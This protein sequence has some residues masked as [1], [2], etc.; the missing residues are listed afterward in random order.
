MAKRLVILLG[1]MTF[2]LISLVNAGFISVNPCDTPVLIT[3]DK[4][5]IFMESGCFQIT[6]PKNYNN[7][8]SFFDK[9]NKNSFDLKLYSF[10]DVNSENDK[11]KRTTSFPSMHFT[12]KIENERVS[13][14]SDD[15]KI[16]L[17]YLIRG[18]KVK[19][20]MEI[21][22]WESS[23]S[24]G[25]LE[26][27]TKIH[28]GDKSSSKFIN[29][30][31][32]VDGK[33]QPLITSS[34]I[35]GQNEFIVQTL[36]EGKSFSFLDIDPLY[37][38]DYSPAPALWYQNGNKTLPT[39][40]SFDAPTN[41]TSIM[42]DN[43]TGTT[44][45]INS[46]P[47][48]G[49]DRLIRTRFNQPYQ[50]GYNY[51]IAIYRPFST[52][53]TAKVLPHINSTHVNMSYYV[54]K[55]ITGTGW[56]YINVTEITEFMDINLGYLDY[57]IQVVPDNQITFSEAWLR[58]E[59]NDTSYP[60]IVNCSVTNN[61]LSCDESATII[62]EV[63][64]D[65][66][67]DNVNFTI[68]GTEY[69]GIQNDSEWYYILNLSGESTFNYT[70]DS[71]EACDIF[72]QC[73][74]ENRTEYVYYDC[75][76]CVEDW[77]DNSGSCLTNDSYLKEYYDNNS[78]GT[79][80]D[81]PMDNGTYPS[82]NYC[83]EDLE[84]V[85]SSC[86]LFFGDYVRDIS[87]QDNNYYSCCALTGISSD[88]SILYSPYNL[89]TIENCTITLEDD[90][91]ITLDL[92]L[93]FGFGFG[94]LASDKTHGKIWINDTNNTYYCVSY[95]KTFEG[96]LVQ[97]NPPYTKRT[98]STISF[99]PKEIE[100]REFFTTYN[101]LANVYWTDNNLV[102]DGRQ[103]VFGVECAGN[104]QN[105]KSEIL[106]T[107]GY[108]PVNA[109]ITRWFWFKENTVPIILGLLLLFIVTI[110]VAIFIRELRRR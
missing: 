96:N 53:W 23:Y 3:E 58:E 100:D 37:Q 101:G 87:Y 108:D 102:I 35:N 107:V 80:D 109:P 19:S 45:N 41:I 66:A 11:Q 71:V 40:D 89:T 93:T 70:F 48:H 65:I 51:W 12:A 14:V 67:I 34:E 76:Y 39:Y 31:S 68:S 73:T 72:S 97:T 92:E 64:D 103:Y 61:N 42:S 10:I 54:T 56:H 62:C 44:V 83:S 88:C 79:Y 6:F 17:Y 28:K 78:C 91:D 105:L 26:L 95:V 55:F 29:L 49:S 8:I 110:V 9:Y 32:I 21:Y 77:I 27:R 38:V 47:S 60:S 90:F 50:E 75:T 30:P 25:K 2:L 4:D 24:S 16:I 81:L 69:Q 85:Y 52:S 36:F 82:C 98:E 1:V 86:Y 46:D 104:S 59:A 94:G 13:Y 74:T 20:G 15:G 43:N 33:E 57:R 22:D 7:D 63:S 18:D 5:N 106:A 99:I 84:Q